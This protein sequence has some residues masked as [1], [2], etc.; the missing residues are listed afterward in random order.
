MQLDLQC[1]HNKLKSISIG[2]V[3][4][5]IANARVFSAVDYNDGS[6]PLSVDELSIKHANQQVC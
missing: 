2:S 3:N 5:P 1:Y 6:A 4:N